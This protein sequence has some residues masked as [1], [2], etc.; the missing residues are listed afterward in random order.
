[1]SVSLGLKANRRYIASHPW[2]RN[3]YCAKS[4]CVYKTGNYYGKV[5]FFMTLEDFKILWFRDKAWLLA[6]P[7]IDRIDN[8][9]DYV[10]KNCRFIEKGENARRANLGKPCSKETRE[11]IRLGNL[12]KNRISAKLYMKNRKRKPNGQF[13]N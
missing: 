10:F 4:R 1:M 7:S 2:A 8:K 6:I 12:G 9:G 5:K 13:I 11:K 3:Y